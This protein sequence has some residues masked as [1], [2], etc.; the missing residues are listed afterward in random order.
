MGKNSNT[1]WQFNQRVC[2]CMCVS[3]HVR[4]RESMGRSRGWGEGVDG[5][6]ECKHRDIPAIKYL[7]SENHSLEDMVMVKM[8]MKC[9]L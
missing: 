2:V 1:C 5:P 7:S 3:V 6:L 9:L 4:D 8:K